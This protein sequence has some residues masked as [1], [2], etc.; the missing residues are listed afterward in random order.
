MEDPHA[1]VLFWILANDCYFFPMDGHFKKEINKGPWAIVALLW[2][3]VPHKLIITHI[4]NRLWTQ[5]G[6][7]NHGN[8]NDIDHIT[9][10][11][12]PQEGVRNHAMNV[13][14]RKHHRNSNNHD[15]QKR[16]YDTREDAKEVMEQMINERCDGWERLNVYYR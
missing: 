15:D 10:R 1:S 9:T 6:V 3:V 14:R 8:S 13:K 7:R 16:P 12:W 2:W 11:R 5:E 4:M